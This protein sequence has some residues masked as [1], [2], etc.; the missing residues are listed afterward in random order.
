[1]TEPTAVAVAVAPSGAAVAVAPEPFCHE[2]GARH[3]ETVACDPFAPLAE[4]E[5]V[6][7][8]VID[9]N[10]AAVAS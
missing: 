9:H 7:F 4:S 6:T 2:C 8:H 3:R 10:G 5:L 1:M